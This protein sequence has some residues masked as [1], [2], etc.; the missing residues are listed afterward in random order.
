M[1]PKGSD[2]ERLAS[3]QPPGPPE[4]RKPRRRG[5]SSKRYSP[6]EKQRL[7]EAFSASGETLEGFCRRAE[8][9]TAS[10]C[11]WRRDFARGG[12][13]ALEPKAN[14]RNTR[15][16]IA[17]KRYTPE[18]RREAVEAF[19]ASG[20]T[21]KEFC[22]VWG[23]N[24]RTLRHWLERYG[25]QGPRG[26]EPGAAADASTGTRA[27]LHA[28]AASERDA[29]FRSPAAD[30]AASCPLSGEARAERGVSPPPSRKTSSPYE[31]PFSSSSPPAR[32]ISPA[33]RQEIVRTR[34]RFDHF[35]LRKVRDFLKRFS[36]IEVSMGT[37][38]KV[39]DEAGIEPQ[40]V[41]S[42]RAVRARPKPR[43]FERAHP[44]ELWQSDITSFV[45]PRPRLRVYLTV[46][47]DDCSRYIV[48]HGLRVHQRQDLV[49]DALLEGI[50]RFGKPKEVLTDQ[51]RQYFAWR[52]KSGFQKLLA[53]E[54][55]QHVVARTHHPQTV[56]KTE[57]FWSTVQKEFWDRARPNDL[58]EAQERLSHFIAHYNHFRPHQ[59]IDGLVPADRFFGAESALRETLEKQMSANEIER[60][61]GEGVQRPLFLFG[62]VGDQQV[63]LHGEK[64]RVVIQTPDGGRQ[65]LRLDELGIP[66]AQ[67]RVNDA[68]EDPPFSGAGGAPQGDE[69]GPR[70]ED[71]NDAKRDDDQP[72]SGERD[73]EPKR[74][75][76]S[77]ERRESDREPERPGERGEPV[78]REEASDAAG[79]EAGGLQAAPALRGAS[80]G[81]VEDGEPRAA[82]PGAPAV[83]GD[84]RVLAGED[85]QA[86][87]GREALAAGPEDLAAVADGAL[88]YAGGPART[89]EVA[90]RGP[91]AE[92]GREPG[93]FGAA[94]ASAR[95]RGQADAD[96]EPGAAAPGPAASAGALASRSDGRASKEESEEARE[97]GSGEKRGTLGRTLHRWIGFGWGRGSRRRSKLD[98][99]G[100]SSPES[101]GSS[102]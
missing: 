38:R 65:E 87:G 8:V 69:D 74:D 15:R 21:R 45:L 58:S 91:H 31:L 79:E 40:P 96:R 83:R 84:A 64:G 33:V 89:T 68:A 57:R 30:E 81:A 70:S 78:A 34:E 55:I 10:L 26:L 35:G 42:R 43:R 12:A 44:G 16:V 49:V 60:A 46:F 6:E 23:I 77:G 52:G 71:G 2:R 99:Q 92:I 53:R 66:A 25:A 61:V 85:L 17:P 75:L 4:L 13:S 36:G 1:E 101:P 94:Q 76:P 54:G 27:G 73:D 86:A 32:G 47:L 5:A 90:R 48:S 9:S 24:P 7:L 28:P 51:G 14:P 95:A 19:I 39:L 50:A 62:Q 98:S 80:A 59:G 93:A 18:Q 3:G 22:R 37:V 56:G 41:P 63:S 11:K 29:G 20:R 67:E 82:E 100:V 102:K 72:D 88:G 97:A